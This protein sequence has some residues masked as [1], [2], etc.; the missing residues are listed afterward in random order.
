MDIYFGFNDLFKY[1]V[2]YIGHVVIR[3]AKTEW[4]SHNTIRSDVDVAII[5]LK[6]NFQYACI[7][8]VMLQ[9]VNLS[10]RIYYGNSNEKTAVNFS[11]NSCERKHFPVSIKSNHL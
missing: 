7:T 10:D 1:H 5:V 4:I 9:S 8:I 3:E 2:F 11:N 6:G